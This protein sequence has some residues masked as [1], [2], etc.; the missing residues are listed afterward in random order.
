MALRTGEGEQAKRMKKAL[1]EVNK[2]WGQQMNQ[3]PNTVV[4]IGRV[5]GGFLF[6]SCTDRFDRRPR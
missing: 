5:W 6:D 4:F 3:V 1:V 2:E